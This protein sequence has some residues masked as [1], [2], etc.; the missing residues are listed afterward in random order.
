[1]DTRKSQIHL[2]RVAIIVYNKM[3]T[4]GAQ[5]LFIYFC[6]LRRVALTFGVL[7]DRV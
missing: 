1:M 7:S 2:R 3:I 6:R 5:N 4:A